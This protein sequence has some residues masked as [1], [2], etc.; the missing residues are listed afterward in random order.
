M[1]NSKV[2]LVTGA[3]GFI[4]SSL[5]K[6]LV[7]SGATVHATVRRS[8]SG[9][10]VKKSISSTA[11]GKLHIFLTP[12]ITTPG[13][14][15][16]ALKGVTHVF[17]T[18]SP[19]PGGEGKTDAKRDFLDPARA[20]TLTLLQD[21]ADAESVKKV[22]YTSSAASVFDPSKL[23]TGNM[24][25]EKD[26]NPITY[27][28]ALKAGEGLKS[29]KKDEVLQASFAVYTASKRVAE[30]AAWDFVKDNK[31]G[32]ALAAV[33]PVLVIGPPTLGEGLSGSNGIFWEKLVTRPVRGED[34]TS[35]YVDV[36]DTVEG[37]IQ[38][39][40][41]AQADGKRFLLTAGQPLHHEVINWAK[42]KQP[43]VDFDKVEVPADAQ[44]QEERQTKFDNALSRDV[45]GLKYRSVRESVERL[46]DWAVQ[47]GA[48]KA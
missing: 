31:P 37:H 2:Y 30:E 46:V 18:A 5:V 7:E 1:S 4:A 36:D 47:S 21:A 43:S 19:L 33:N 26:W 16:D 20:G 48:A 17:H 29:D 45:L 40:E 42:A 10:D 23:T 22:V 34:A 3:N 35:A 12:D 14:F 13:A 44:E 27:E 39:M 38:A 24:H 25:D 28:Y 9:D 11:T 41:R 15:R 6:R 8:S 32:F